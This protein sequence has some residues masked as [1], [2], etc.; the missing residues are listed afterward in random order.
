MNIPLV[1]IVINNRP[2]QVRA[3]ASV[4]QACEEA[5][6]DIPRFCYHEKLSVAG[7]CRMCLVEI[8]KSPKPVVSCAM[9]VS[10]GM[11]I[12]TES[13]LVKKA[14]EA[15]LEFLLINHPLDCPICDQGGECDLQDETLQYASDRSRF[16]EFKRSVE[17]KECGPIV[18]T[19]M[20]RC[21]HCTRCI[22]FSSE[23]AGVE[24][25]GSFGR[26]QETEIGT[27]VQ[28]F[29]KTE[30]SG[31]LVDLCPVGALTSKPYAFVARNWEL[32]KVDTIDFFDGMCADISVHT[33]KLTRPVFEKGKQKIVSKDEIVRILP[34]L[35]GLYSD[36]WISDKTRYA[37]DGLNTQRANNPI[38]VDKLTGN[39]TLNWLDLLIDV[40]ERLEPNLYQ[41]IE[42]KTLQIIKP[43]NIT[44][45]VGNI[46]D[47]ESVYVLS[48]FMKLYGSSNI[49]YGNFK[50]K[51]NI[52][53]PFYFGLNRTVSSFENLSALILIGSN[54]RYEASILNTFLRK[55]QNAR[56]VPIISFSSFAPLRLK[57]NHLGNNL[58][59]LISFSE[60]R[61][62][63]ATSFYNIA[64][65]SILFGIDTLKNK[66][67]F[68]LQNIARFIGKKLFVKTKSGD[69]L[70]FL[71][72]NV[73]SLAFTYLGIEAGVR[74]NLHSEELKNK[75][76][77]TLFGIQIND[78]DKRKWISSNPYTNTYLFSTNKVNTIPFDRL[79]PIKSLYEKEGFLI[80]I[81]GRLR[82]FQKAVSTPNN[83]RSLESFLI[84]ISRIQHNWTDALKSFWTIE[85]ELPITNILEK[86][87]P[88]FHI[89]FLNKFETQN[90]GALL[91]FS[92]TIP[93]FYLN[94]VISNNSAT[95]GECA[96]FLQRE[97]NLTKEF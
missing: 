4:L 10:K 93:N 97:T 39:T 5:S 65:P 95:M 57:Q 81:E 75:E 42:K 32:Q 68:M 74:S 37:F 30:L 52:S 89:N 56:G 59:S 92:P 29:I 8:Q 14:R 18:K 76:I 35:D 94:D 25:M 66:S 62:K 31:N 28:S 85:E 22:R 53:A 24:T 96:L 84:A 16:F 1:N 47:V 67:G 6:I 36:N 50:N 19:I 63:S 7:N 12:F 13:P 41:S 72:N 20:T 77:D 73:T 79:I 45:I 88:S 17:D 15:V 3:N 91:P 83:V 44:S 87:I 51:V 26:G 64:S 23:I 54:P 61:F 38:K 49:Q 11:V 33:R 27:Y 46:S 48:Q 21:I 80:N 82:K 71:H 9:P 34:K 2:Y 69:R 55:Q 60:N 78:L 70:S 86:E 58:R 43:Y 90:K 40:S